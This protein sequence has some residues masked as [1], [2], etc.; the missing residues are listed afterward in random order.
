MD[1]LRASTSPA[2]TVIHGEGLPLGRKPSLQGEGMGTN[3][4]VGANK[5]VGTQARGRIRLPLQTG[6]R[7]D[8]NPGDSSWGVW[9]SRT[10]RGGESR[11]QGLWGRRK[12][13]WGDEGKGASP[14]WILGQEESGRVSGEA[15]TFQSLLLV[16]WARGSSVWGLPPAYRQS[17]SPSDPAGSS[18]WLGQASLRAH[19][20]PQTALLSFLGA[21]TP[22]SPALGP[23]P[24]SA[25][26]QISFSR[27]DLQT[28]QHGTV[29][30][31]GHL[32]QQAL[33]SKE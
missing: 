18:P 11:S 10:R 25:P 19:S 14:L 3:K 15:P 26:D 1:R 33:H 30:D 16:S 5:A 2:L 23:S 6:V 8:G 24:L 7:P 9:R 20:I 21:T 13:G 22:S 12:E 31:K 32:H 28:S 17:L 29:R 27:K 4:A